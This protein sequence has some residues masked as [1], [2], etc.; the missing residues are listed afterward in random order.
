MIIAMKT[1]IVF[2]A[3]VLIFT[4]EAPLRAVERHLDFKVAERIEVNDSV[5][6]PRETLL[7]YAFKGQR[8]VLIVKIGNKDTTFPITGR[9]HLFPAGTTEEG[10]R[11]W[12]QNQHQSAQLS[13]VPE[14]ASVIVLPGGACRVVKSKK[15]GTTQ[16]IGQFGGEFEQFEVE[17]EISAQ[18]VGGRIALSRF[19]DKAKVQVRALKPELPPLKN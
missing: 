16:H 6:G 9:V 13:R 15:T 5:L 8:A 7:I 18:K 10:L 3:A 12:I 4:F 17:I 1:K 11:D 2:A 19:S 14:P